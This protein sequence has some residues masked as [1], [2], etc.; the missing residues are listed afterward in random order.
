MA[1]FTEFNTVYVNIDLVEIIRVEYAPTDDPEEDPWAVRV[2]MPRWTASEY[3]RTEEEAKAR[4]M[5]LF[6]VIRSVS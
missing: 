1:A 6:S 3:F 2:I 4:M 5:R